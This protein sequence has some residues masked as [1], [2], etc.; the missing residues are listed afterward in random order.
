MTRYFILALPLVALSACSSM[1]S[2]MNPRYLFNPT[3]ALRGPIVDRPL[4]SDTAMFMIQSDGRLTGDALGTWW[5][6]NRQFCRTIEKPLK[7]AGDR[8]EDVTI[9]DNLAIF[10][11]ADGRAST[12]KIN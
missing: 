10:T 1:P 8:C 5:V 6:E 3:Q 12:Y 11:Q 7:W 9:K 2:K 4:T